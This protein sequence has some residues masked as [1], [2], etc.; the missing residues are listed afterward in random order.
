[1]V[2][3]GGEKM[4]AAV[5]CGILFGSSTLRCSQFKNKLDHHYALS[6][7]FFKL[8]PLSEAAVNQARPQTVTVSFV[9]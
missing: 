9:I 2:V 4:L 3:K 8:E 6:N 7:F 1:M 5:Q